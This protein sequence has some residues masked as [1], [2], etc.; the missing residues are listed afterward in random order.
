MGGANSIQKRILSSQQRMESGGGNRAHLR[1]GGMGIVNSRIIAT[2]EAFEK[3]IESQQI[4]LKIF[5]MHGS[6]RAPLRAEEMQGTT[7][8]KMDMDCHGSMSGN[9]RR[10]LSKRTK[11]REKLNRKSRGKINPNDP[12]KNRVE[13]KVNNQMYSQSMPLKEPV[14]GNK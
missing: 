10:S 5:D 2:N 8:Y 14:F 7:L 6:I 4:P 12:N 3:E 9:Q 1:N 11:S 13:Y